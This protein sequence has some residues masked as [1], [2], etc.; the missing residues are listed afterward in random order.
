MH[1]GRGINFDFEG[2][3]DA[4]VTINSRKGHS[5]H[6]IMHI[7]CPSSKGHLNFLHG[8]T[9]SPSVFIVIAV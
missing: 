9:L 6:S 3:E 8:I 7:L 4:E 5:R 1:V 2:N